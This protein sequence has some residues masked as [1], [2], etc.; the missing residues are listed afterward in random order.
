MLLFGYLAQTA[1]IDLFTLLS[2]KS[3]ECSDQVDD[4]HLIVQDSLGNVVQTQYIDMD[5]VTI[6]LRNFYISA[7]LG[8]SSNKAPKFWLLFEVSV[9]PLGWNTYF[10]SK[11]TTKGKSLVFSSWKHYLLFITLTAFDCIFILGGV[12]R[13]NV[14]VMD[15]VQKRI[16]NIGPGNLKMSFSAS[17]QAI[18]M[19]NS[20]NGVRHLKSMIWHLEFVILPTF[21][22]YVPIWLN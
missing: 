14:S 16:V 7:Y 4:E 19:F 8:K 20:K 15:K 6:S 18:K 13:S 9:P 10:V 17:D 1:H 22:R 21:Q 11:K 5:N 12:E 2:V 3:N